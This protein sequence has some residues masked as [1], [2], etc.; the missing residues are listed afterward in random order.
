MLPIL[1]R[2]FNIF[3]VSGLVNASFALITGLFVFLKNSRSKLNR[4]FFY[5]CLCVGGWSLFWFL[6]YS[7]YV[8]SYALL[9]AIADNLFAIFLALFYMHFI[10]ALIGKDEEKRKLIVISYVSNILLFLLVLINPRL[11][12]GGVSKPKYID[13]PFYETDPGIYYYIFSLFFALEV[14]YAIYMMIRIYPKLTGITKNQIKYTILG[15]VIGFISGGL[16]FLP[17]YGIPVPLYSNLFV[18][19]GFA[20]LAYSIIRY[21]LMEI[22]TIIHRTILWVFTSIVIF[23]PISVMIYFLRT[24]L[25]ALNWIQSAFLVTI[26]VYAYLFFYPKVQPR[27][28]HL[29]RRRKYGYQTVLGKVAE[30]IS[31]TINMEDLASH[32]LSEVCETMYLRNSLLYVLDREGNKYV[33]VGRRGY[34]EIDGVRQSSSLETYSENKKADFAANLRELSCESRFCRWFTEYRDVLEKEQVELDPRY[35]SIR[36]EALAWFAVQDTEL[37]IP[38]LYENKVTAILGLGRKESLQAYTVEDIKL[39]K[40]LGEE[41]GVTV[42][43]SLHHEDLVEKERLDEE[44]RMGRQI[45]TALLP[46]ETPKVPGLFVQG[47][48][49]PAKEIGGDYYDFIPLPDKDQLAVVIGD[50]SG[51]GVSAGLIMSLTKATIHAFSEEGFSPR[52]I[53]L[54]TNRFLNK[55]ISGEKFMTLLYLAWQPDNK[56]ITYSSAGHE[57]ILIWRNSSQALEVIK[58]GGFMLG[59]IKNIDSYLEE[60]QLKLEFQDKI[61]IYTDGVTEAENQ[62]G[63]RFGLDR[64]KSTVI[65]NSQKP[66]HELIQ[67]VKD[68]VYSFIGSH[69]QYDDITLVALEAV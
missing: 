27:I 2:D 38:L 52:E 43:N 36:Q 47:M 57:H 18:W 66:A 9:Y 37:L 53:L 10:L 21:R 59:I 23:I 26:L 6:A 41:A 42:F 63:D 31:T 40:K 19:F 67:A 32:L 16:S 69:P 14:F 7:E 54:R 34:Q 35:E 17:S 65:K 60:K 45:Q 12:L 62:E 25:A 4:N 22:D 44:M 51:K 30:K 49:L 3:A 33:L 8:E 55:H 24:W 11:F 48:M 61:L 1:N 20:I 46:H 50:V 68:E 29:F 13:I 64:L 39:L 58:S 5:M 56:T 15:S 28:D